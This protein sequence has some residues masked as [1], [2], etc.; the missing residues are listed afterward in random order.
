MRCR[1]SFWRICTR[2]RI[3]TVR[4][5]DRMC[6]ACRRASA[7]RPLTATAVVVDAADVAEARRWLTADPDQLAALTAEAEAPEPEPEAQS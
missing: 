6:P 1:E 2:C 3:T 7:S 5:P 4:V